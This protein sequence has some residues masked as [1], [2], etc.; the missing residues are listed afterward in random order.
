MR[1]WVMRMASAGQTSWQQLQLIQALR[2]S[3]GLWVSGESVTAWTGQACSHFPHPMQVVSEN[4]GRTQTSF[5]KMSA[6]PCG[7]RFRR[8]AP[9]GTANDWIVTFSP[10]QE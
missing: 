5:P 4:A 6:S 8:C 3:M 7:R 9:F 10:T 2:L 1:D